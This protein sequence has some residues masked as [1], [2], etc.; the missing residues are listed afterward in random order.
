M[1]LNRIQKGLLL[2]NIAVVVGF[3]WYYLQAADYEFLAYAGTIAV[4]TAL[5]F[6]TLK[7]S[8]FSN[9]IILGVTIWGLLHM[10]GGSVMT[11]DGVLYAWRIFPFFDGGGE[12]YI[13]KFDQ[14]VHAFLYGIVGLMFYH[15]LREVVGVK[16]H[17]L[18]VAAVAIFAGAG[19]SIIN[20]IIEFLAAVNIPNTGVGG[21]H[22][23]VLDMIFNLAGALIAVV[24]KVGI[25]KRN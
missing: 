3:S 10:L 14:V 7:W 5:L 16:T 19:F 6:G 8:R 17:T 25:D 23:T 1:K 2:V 12:F 13:L 21:Y 22:N 15:L 4:V 18:L 24:I 11:A 9:G 20:E